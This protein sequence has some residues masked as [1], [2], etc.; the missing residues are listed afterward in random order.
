MLKRLELIGFKSFA[1]KT[2]FDFAPGV[3]AVVGPNGSGKSNIV[4]AV[5]WILGEQS[6]K[7]LR[8]GEMSDVIFNGSSTRKSLGMA[9]VTMTFDN[10]KRQLNFDGDEVQL[11]RRVYRDGQGEYL[12]NGTL[13]RLKD[14]KEMFLGSG[15][16]QG[17]Y[18]IIEQGRV[19]ALL[20]AST[21]DR[22]HIFEEAAGISRFR[23]R[24]MDTL[25]KLEDVN[26]KLDRVRDILQELEKNLQKLTAQA[27]KAQKYQEHHAR[28]RDLRIGVGLHEYRE[29]AET[30]T[31]QEGVLAN[32]RAAVSDAT[33]QTD[34]GETTV[35][36]LEWDL[37]RADESLRVQEKRL[38]EA[39]QQIAEFEA[40][41]KSG[42]EQFAN[43]E[44]ESLRLGKQRA[45]L[46]IRLRRLEAELA[47]ATAEATDSA[48]TVEA[49]QDRADA[50]AS[51][52][53]V[54]TATI[55]ELTRQAQADREQQFAVVGRAAQFHSSAQMNQSQ[56]E[57]LQR[58]LTRMKAKA[59]RE[60][61]EA[62]AIGQ[63][64]DDLSRSDADV[65]QRLAA[66]RL[67]LAELHDRQ[68]GFRR[69]ADAI[70][71]ELDSLRELR[72]ALRGRADVLENLERSLEGIGA[73]VRS[74]LEKLPQPAVLGL[75]AD[76][77]TV[78]RDVAP[79]IDIAL[80]EAAQRFVVR[81]EAV[82]EVLQQFANLPGRV[83]FIPLQLAGGA[84]EPSA[85]DLVA[86]D[87]ADLPRQL[88]GNVLI[89]D[90]LATARQLRPLHPQHRFVTRH[91]ELLEPDGTI[92]VG[93]PRT[94]AGIV[95]RKSELRELREQIAN[96]EA[97]LLTLETEQSKLRHQAD[98]LDAPISGRD[99]E[100]QT[101]A[102]E[103]GT[104]RDRITD[105]RQRRERL[106]EQAELALSEA[107]VSAKDLQR[108]ET[109]WQDAKQFAEEA[110]AESAKLRTRLAQADE[111]VRA[112]EANRETRQAENTAAQV[113]LT[114]VKQQ[115]AALRSRCAELE[116]ET[117]QRKIDAINLSSTE[118][119]LQSRLLDSQLAMLRATAA[120]AQ[121]YTDKETRQQAVA[122]WSAKRESLR[123]ERDRVQ[124][125]LRAVRDAWKQR[126]DQA[127]AHELTVRDLVN[128]RDGITGRLRED[129]QI[130]LTELA[131]QDSP[132][133]ERPFD[134]MQDEID[135]LK[136]KLTK[137]GSVNL[138]AL[139]QLA[140]EEAREKKYREEYE[141]VTATETALLAIIEQ[142]NTDSRR[143]FAE[144]LKA[145]TAH[146]Q[147]LFRKLFGGGMA[148]IV[149]EDPAD[150]LETGI[151]IQA[152]PPGKELRSISLMSGGEKTLT[153]IAL[154]LAIFRSRPSPFC[155]LDE[156]D[157][158]LDEA[159]TG[160]LADIINEFREKSQFIIVTHKKRTMTMADVLHGVTMQESGVS[161]QVATR[162]DDW[163]DEPQAAA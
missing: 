147:E 52:L 68:A 126:Q 56:V 153:A 109:A 124:E 2:R 132:D 118:R 117:R 67:G 102:G 9:E 4:D 122:E 37:G 13:A 111:Q 87:F 33:A 28:L 78:P 145:V 79:L 66:A 119:T 121:A 150:I 136:R 30:L 15:A 31:Y 22:R 100:I 19:D 11:T 163:P 158:A 127:H 26:A 149:L 114:R 10:A 73:G 85:A 123:A 17:A 65:Q 50:A 112:A 49:E 84:S 63:A 60:T 44:G 103:A 61:A 140:A 101:L 116:S 141:D 32:L 99:A 75:V 27:A 161:K 91:G 107:A 70:Q 80:G 21:K 69:Q 24:K 81:G 23:V 108:A 159:N 93:P 64:L 58:E 133:L 96:Q 54:V 34:A 157:A 83:G 95:S 72:S 146:F 151:E 144:T 8:G 137:L 29:L 59:D 113:A 125:E 16:G 134:E 105:Q 129:Y 12:V 45:E 41:V 148:D 18:S 46:T 6:A 39:R 1:D 128:R 55:T 156:V 35:G 62:N 106:T 139:E 152:R 92:T 131:K 135:D 90:D 57:R 42:R 94:D 98:A 88:L 74:V 76:L 14:I 20:V 86:C 97:R 53:N 89:V 43:A 142:I 115:L 143:L 25:R 155:L 162:I 51:A 48:A 130:E 36:K 47:K 3:T 5:K 77:L 138:E 110:D 104:L 160:R 7:S 154:L 38:G 120:A 40:A 82:D 71:P